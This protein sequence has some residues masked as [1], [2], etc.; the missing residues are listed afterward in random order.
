M[1]TMMMIFQ[2]LAERIMEQLVDR[3][4][5][6]DAVE[7]LVDQVVGQDAVESLVEQLMVEGL[8]EHLAVPPDAVEGTA[9]ITAATT[10]LR[11]CAVQKVLI[12]RIKQTMAMIK[13]TSS[14][15]LY[16][17]ALITHASI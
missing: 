5:G 14:A 6:Q 1:M 12:N 8:V 17:V 13:Q 9:G 3:V 16:F 7:S 10:S 2:L 11:L 15:A 4:V